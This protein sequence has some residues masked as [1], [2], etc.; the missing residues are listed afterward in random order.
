[1]WQNQ[2]KRDSNADLEPARAVLEGKKRTDLVEEDLVGER[3]QNR[4]KEKRVGIKLLTNYYREKT[5]F[6]PRTTT[7]RLN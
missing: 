6:F 5:V 7:D 2:W 4:K 3:G 1:M